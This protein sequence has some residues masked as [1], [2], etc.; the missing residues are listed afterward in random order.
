MVKVCMNK[1]FPK[2]HISEK[3][4]F[5]RIWGSLHIF[6]NVQPTLVKNLKSYR[7]N[8]YKISGSN[9]KSPSN[10][11]ISFSKQGFFLPP[12]VNFEKYG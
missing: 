2:V 7:L 4:I 10:G 11:L 9:F 12:K 6:L 8:F 5:K 3:Q 1:I